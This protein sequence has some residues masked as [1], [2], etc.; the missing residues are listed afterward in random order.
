MLFLLSFDVGQTSVSSEKSFYR[1]TTNL[2]YSGSYLN[3]QNSGW[4]L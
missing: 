2:E 4:K 3:L 1:V